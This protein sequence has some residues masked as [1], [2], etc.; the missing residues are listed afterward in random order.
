MIDKPQRVTIV[1]IGLM[2]GL[3]M[4]SMEVTV[5]STAMPSIVAELGGLAMYSWVFAAYMV[6]ST[7]TIPIFGKLSDL[8]G[9]RPVYVASLLLFLV[10]SLLCG[11]AKS[12]TQLVIFRA[13]QGLGAGGVLPLT[14]TMIG[15]MF[16]LEQRA[17]MQ[18]VTSS[19][20]GLS[21][22]VGPLLGGFLVDQV[23]WPWVFYVNIG[24]GILAL[25]LIWYGW[26]DERN[27][28]KASVTIDY[29]GAILLTAAIVL[30]LL[31]LMDI[32]SWVGW[33]LLA[34]M[35]VLCV[36]LLWVERRAKEPVLPLSLF[37][38]RMYAIACLHG[39]LAGAAMFGC[40]SYV[41][42]F[43]QVAFGASATEAGAA[44]TP[45]IFGWVV[46]SVI[47]GR[48]L[49]R[50]G[51][52]ALVLSG[53][54]ALVMGALLMSQMG[55]HANQIFVLSS[56][57]LMGVGM[58]LAIPAF[59][60]VVQSTVQRHVL[61]AATST[62]QFTRTVGG[63][64]GVSIMGVVLS[65][66]LAAQLSAAGLDPASVSV[67]TLLEHAKDAT[68]S[69]S[70]AETARTALTTATQSVFFVAFLF[71]ALALL[72]VWFTPRGIPLHGPLPGSSAQKLQPEPLEIG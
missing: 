20:W 6:T 65:R 42:L 24:P 43:I 66:G 45:M 13:I 50:I 47:G 57:T 38:G 18:G 64:I 30:L 26:H 10:G 31:G 56:L 32:E 8:Y 34:L 2:L 11:Q 27:N 67:E 15:A 61:G 1:T 44:L 52:L 55:G 5:V 72:A 35:V 7:T 40:I 68:T 36:L 16:S 46:A 21:S 59:L 60:I 25:L 49:L 58:G 28:A 41:P 51:Y 23:S 33:A 63:T 48:L 62:L 12:M 70:L 29:P 71:A 53:G 4:S 22:V 19:I 39:L 17:K 54:I 3:F 69:S 37:R 14:F 9:R